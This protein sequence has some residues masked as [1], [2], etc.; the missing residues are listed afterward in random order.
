[1][2]KWLKGMIV[3]TFI[4]VLAMAAFLVW[5]EIRGRAS[6]DGSTPELFDPENPPLRKNPEQWKEV[7]NKRFGDLQAHLN[8]D[9][10][11]RWEKIRDF[12]GKDV[13][14]HSKKDD[15]LFYGGKDISFKFWKNQFER[16]P[17]LKIVGFEVKDVT[18]YDVNFPVK[19]LGKWDR[20]NQVAF[21][22]GI[23]TKA[24]SPAESGDF[25]GVAGHIQ[26]CPDIVFNESY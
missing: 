6:D 13:V 18:V 3:W 19:L 9:G 10:K 14:L 5:K 7:L 23:L 8:A 2:S 22:R 1:M 26:S 20:L 12:Y 4:L 25:Y 17:E 11:G 24:A 21:F 16:T 15:T